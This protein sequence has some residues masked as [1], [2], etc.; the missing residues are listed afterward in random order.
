MQKHMFYFLAAFIVGSLI[1][2]AAS[3][4][5][6]LL[7]DYQTRQLYSNRTNSP[8]K[9]KDS[10]DSGGIS[11]AA[12][13][14][15]SAGEIENGMVC[16]NSAQIRDLVCY[17]DCSCASEYEYTESYCRSVGKIAAGS[18]CN[19]MYTQ[20]ICDTS[21]YPHTSSSCV[22]S[23][24][25]SLCVDD[26]G[27]HYENCVT[28]PCADKEIVT[29]GKA[30]GCAET[31]DADGTKCIR[32]NEQP[33]CGSDKYWAGD[34]LGCV[35]YTC[36]VDF[37]ANAA[38]C[39]LTVSNSHWE[40]GTE[41]SG[42]SGSTPCYNCTLRCDA[43]YADYDDYWC[44]QKPQTIDCETL[45]YSQ[46]TSGI[47][48]SIECANGATK[49]A[50]PF[51]KNYYTCV[52]ERQVYREDPDPDPDPEPVCGTS[53]TLSSCPT[54]GNCAECGGKYRLND[55][56]DGYAVSGETCV[57]ASCPTGYAIMAGGCGTVP[58]NGK[59]SIGSTINGYSGTFACKNCI[60]TCDSGYKPSGS[61][62][63]A[64]NCVMPDKND[65]YNEGPSD[66]DLY[67]DY[68]GCNS[69][70]MVEFDEAGYNK[71]LNAYNAC[72]ADCGGS[73]CDSKFTLSSCPTGASCT[74][75]GGKYY[76][77]NST[78]L[79][80]YRRL[81]STGQCAVYDCVDE[82]DRVCRSDCDECGHTGDTDFC[83][84]CRDCEYNEWQNYQDCVN[85]F[86]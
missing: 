51:D 2:Q 25:G 20:C 19:G 76:W 53:F 68:E 81:K 15:L 77:D 14:M 70:G 41:K 42:Q 80:G 33:D 11:C 71:D 65:Y 52:G 73:A 45:G 50:C 61:S 30:L 57:A 23:L 48:V 5:V 83:Q 84:W 75:C 7:P 64:C 74:S 60:L 58:A 63:V 69:Q 9:G 55:C 54:N 24:S 37:A 59:W 79:S 86:Y 82:T 39:G 31:C 72:V 1:A 46:K 27:S 66:C 44:N 62:C 43:Y 78:C 36:P 49:L 13:G 16:K 10:P 28:D 67:G 4:K 85:L 3:A 56:K 21:L 22:P 35:V 6:W 18:P 47:F 32:C 26:N 12:Y 17:S 40:L 8:E 38:D 34:D 29:C